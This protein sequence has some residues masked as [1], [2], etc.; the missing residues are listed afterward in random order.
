MKRLL[1]IFLALI[2]CPL[3]WANPTEQ[4]LQK[5]ENGNVEAQYDVGT[6]FLADYENVESA[7]EAEYWLTLAAQSGHI[8]AKYKLAELHLK[9]PLSDDSIYSA[10]FWLTDLAL[11]GET[12]AQL[13]LGQ[14]FE[15]A[16]EPINPLKLAEVWYLLSSRHSPAAEEAYAKILEKQ[17]NNRRASQVSSIDQFS[18]A[19]E[20]VEVEGQPPTVTPSSASDNNRYLDM[21]ITLSVI[22]LV[23]VTL[24]VVKRVRSKQRQEQTNER[25][26][27]KQQVKQQ[28]AVI[29]KQ[30][31]Q[32]KSLFNQLKKSQQKTKNSSDDQ[33]LTVA[34][35]MFGFTARSIPNERVIKSRFKQLSTLYHPDRAGS[36]DEMK[37]LNAALKVL[38]THVNNM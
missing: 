31:R 9:Q 3:L 37:R 26:T 11:S 17:F 6:I 34:C 22:L 14:L 7:K 30:N 15:S 16:S 28:K 20:S 29:D 36:D 32:L 18:V 10:V 12:R 21:I 19:F 13:I 38:L 27:L 33:R 24:L 35:A 5:A 1:V 8:N 2:V 25:F 4:Q 23:S